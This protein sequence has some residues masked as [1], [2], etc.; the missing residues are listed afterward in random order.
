MP[1]YIN[2]KFHRIDGPA[3]VWSDGTKVWYLN[4]K[5]HRLDGHACEWYDGSKEWCIKSINYT[6][7]EKMLKI[8]IVNNKG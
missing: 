3:I 1:Y 5:L 4:G 7:I 2:G 8:I 6:N